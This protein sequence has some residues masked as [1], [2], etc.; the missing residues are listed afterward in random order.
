MSNKCSPH[1]LNQHRGHLPP[2][3]T[4][5]PIFGVGINDGSTKYSQT[6]V[7]HALST[8]RSIDASTPLVGNYGL[9]SIQ[10]KVEGKRLAKILGPIIRA[11]A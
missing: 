9:S 3:K 11:L 2:E 7:P 6:T 10:L 5:A 4:D 8:W 1:G